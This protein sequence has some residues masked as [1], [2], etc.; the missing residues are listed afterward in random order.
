MTGK[1]GKYKS[2]AIAVLACWEPG[3]Y[4]RI[5][6]DVRVKRAAKPPEPWKVGMKNFLVGL[7]GSSPA[8]FICITNIS[9]NWTGSRFL[10]LPVNIESLVLEYGNSLCK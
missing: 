5:W 4:C 10:L 6:I 2:L 1:I 9:W 3:E 7:P 8:L